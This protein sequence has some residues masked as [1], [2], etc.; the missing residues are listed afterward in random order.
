MRI[1]S[2]NSQTESVLRTFSKWFNN[3]YYKQRRSSG[4]FFLESLVIKNSRGA[5]LFVEKVNNKKGT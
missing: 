3:Y 4:A 1:N 2:S 5:S